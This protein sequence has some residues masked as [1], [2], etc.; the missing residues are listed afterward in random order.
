MFA[1][2]GLIALVGAVICMVGMVFLLVAAFQEGAL[3]GAGIL[4]FPPI[5]GLVFAVRYWRSGGWPFVATVVGF[6]MA[7]VGLS[8]LNYIAQVLQSA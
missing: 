6:A 1:M 7:V 8:L 3:W 2:A 5:V 4:L